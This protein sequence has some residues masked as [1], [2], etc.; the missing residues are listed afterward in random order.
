MTHGQAAQNNSWFPILLLS[1]GNNQTRGPT[2]TC[3]QKVVNI[4]ILSTWCCSVSLCIPFLPRSARLQLSRGQTCHINERV[5]TEV[6]YHQVIRF[7]ILC[8]LHISKYQIS[9]SSS[10]SMVKCQG[11]SEEPEFEKFST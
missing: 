2:T 3:Q 6:S 11:G 4:D 1:R 7:L 9:S 5:S 8:S 10:G